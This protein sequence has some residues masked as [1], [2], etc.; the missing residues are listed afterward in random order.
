MCLS[1]GRALIA[2]D[3]REGDEM[4]TARCDRAGGER[5][6]QDAVRQ[7]QE[8]LRRIDTRRRAYRLRQDGVTETEIAAILDRPVPEVHRMIR[9]V[10]EMGDHVTAEE[11]I[12]RAAVDGSDRNALVKTL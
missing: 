11:V 1:A 7:A 9:S 8:R 5:I 2:L 3:V 12:L 10:E 4:S 6:G